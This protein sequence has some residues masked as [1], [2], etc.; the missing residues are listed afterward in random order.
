MSTL[1]AAFE[2]EDAAPGD[3][4][5]RRLI[6][7]LAVRAS[8]SLAV[9]VFDIIFEVTTAGG[10][11]RIVRIAALIGV[12]VNVAYYAAARAAPGAR[13]Q[14]YVRMLIDVELITLGLYGAGGL[15]AA[16]Y[17][18]VYA[19]VP[20]YAG[21]VFS[22]RA[23]LLATAL[24]AISYLAVAL[25]TSRGPVT[26]MGSAWVIAAFNLL[27][28]AIV[29]VDTAILAEAYRRRWPRSAG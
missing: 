29:G 15:A 21:L 17:L 28:V 18:G 13:F 26:A 14:A 11:N 20:V 9:L 24:A 8:V 12:L 19:V 4:H 6:Q 27:I 2:R 1:A 7:E 3:R 5:H 22:S 16:P 23:C 10:G 25:A